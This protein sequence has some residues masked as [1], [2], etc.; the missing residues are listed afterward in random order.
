MFEEEENNTWYNA[1]PKVKQ[2]PYTQE[3]KL[4][5]VLEALSDCAKRRKTKYDSKIT[6]KIDYKIGDLVLVKT[7]PQS[8][9]IKKLN[10]KWKFFYEGPYEVASIPFSCS[11]W[12][13]KPQT[14]DP[15]GLYP[16][17]DL[18]KFVT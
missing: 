9:G 16:Y 13:V 17:K 6:R 11:Y 18:K 7:H 8:S 4:N 1:I 3:D 15:K 14:R 5:N 2:E 12:L 10:K